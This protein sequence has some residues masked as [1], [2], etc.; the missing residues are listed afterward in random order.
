MTVYFYISHT[1][2]WCKSKKNILFDGIY[3]TVFSDVFDLVE[4]A[5]PSRS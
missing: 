1:C 2:K 3:V 5:F 4:A